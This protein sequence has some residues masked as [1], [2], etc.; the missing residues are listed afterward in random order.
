MHRTLLFF[1]F[2]AAAA[3]ATIGADD[4]NA[5]AISE[6]I[7]W[8]NERDDGIIHQ[9][10]HITNGRGLQVKSDA[11][12]PIEKGEVIVQIPWECTINSGKKY[13]PD[14]TE[15]SCGVIYKLAKELRRG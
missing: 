9:S 13:S 12:K 5:T 10:L 11:A 8:I 6:L 4:Y 14:K 7:A 1:L 2:G 15:M 3:A